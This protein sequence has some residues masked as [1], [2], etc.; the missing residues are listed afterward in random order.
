M[1]VEEDPLVF[2]GEQ[3]YL[4]AI[5]HRGPIAAAMISAAEYHGGIFSVRGEQCPDRPINHM[6]PIVGYGTT[7]KS[8]KY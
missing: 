8:D 5:Y 3:D 4:K 7:N 2:S 6:V 1:T